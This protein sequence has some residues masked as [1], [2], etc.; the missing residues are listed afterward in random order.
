MPAIVQSSFLDLPILGIDRDSVRGRLEASYRSVLREDLNLGRDV[1]YV[2]NRMVPFLRLYR[3]K[4]AFSLA[5]VKAMLTY[6][7]PNSRCM[8]FDP[9]AGMG[10][11]L[12]GA[13]LR[14]LPALG[15]ERLP[16]AQF[17]AATLPRFLQAEPGTV[18]RAFEQAR[19]RVDTS[20]PAPIADDVPLMRIAFS[21]ATKLRL[22]RW[23]SAIDAVEG[24]AGDLL[25]LLFFSILVPASY[26]SN[27]GQFLRLRLDKRP[28]DPDELLT[29]QIQAAEEDLRAAQQRWPHLRIRPL[30]P[31]QVVLGDTRDLSEVEFPE[32]P[33]LLI[34]SPPYANRYDYTRSYCLELCFGFVRSFAELKALRHSILR[35][36][37]EVKSAIGDVPCHPALDEVVAALAGKK[38]NNPRIPAMLVAYFVDMRRAINEWAR[39]LA[40]GAGV[41][42]VVD[43]VR[44]EGEMVP[45]DLIL[46]DLA[47]EAGFAVT[48]VIVA[49]YKGNSSQQ[50][51]RYGRVPVR[52]SVVLWEKKA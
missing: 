32:S 18:A 28:A 36:H 1:S 46:S 49:R 3:Y 35:S 20:P 9:F 22:R 24:P 39:V 7:A 37:I 43:N 38:L 16:I 6:L 19:A 30:L 47:Q 31:P 5:F 4:E 13:M 41:A 44:F 45:V 40:P 50:M 25:R 51:G 21:P 34:T 2:G 12:F 14:G 29:C 23:K 8:V 48:E 17:V 15:V 26:T 27:D 11:T 10:T 42:L 33:A 52:E